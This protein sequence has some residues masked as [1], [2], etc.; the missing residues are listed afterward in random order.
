MYDEYGRDSSI[1]RARVLGEFPT[2]SIEGLIKRAWLDA[3]FDRYE[4]EQRGDARLIPRPILALDVGSYGPDKSCCS[5]FYGPRVCKIVSWQGKSLIET[6]DRVIEIGKRV[7]ARDI[8]NRLPTCHVE[9]CGLGIG[10]YDILVDK[11][12][13]AKKFNGAKSASDGEKWLNLRSESLWWLRESLESGKVALPRD[14]KLAQEALAVEF[15]VAPNGSLQMTKKD[16]MKK[17]LGRSPD[18]LDSV[19]LGLFASTAPYRGPTVSFEAVS[20]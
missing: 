6:A 15:F 8:W 10:V 12:Y 1:V 3:A 20:A 14:E 13:P 18:T 2:E 17:E 4:E 16:L 7:Q 5:T 19:T 11:H 9:S